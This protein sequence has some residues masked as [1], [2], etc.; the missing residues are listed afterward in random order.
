MKRTVLLVSMFLLS[1]AVR[2]QEN[3]D[4]CS[5]EISLLTC[6]PGADLYSLFGHTAIRVV[7][8]KRG[9]DVVYNYGTFDDSDPAFYL[10]FMRG[11][12]RYSLSAETTENFMQEYEYG[13]RGVTAQVLNLGCDEKNKLFQALRKNTLEEN[14]YYDYFF[15]NDNCTTRAGVMIESQAGDSLHFKNILPDNLHSK[16]TYRDLIHEYL[17]REAATWSEFG[18]DLFLGTNLDKKVSNMD[19]IHFLPDYLFKGLDSAVLRNKPLVSSKKTL[20]DFPDIEKKAGPFRPLSVFEFIFLMTILLFIFNSAPRV[21]KTL[22]FFDIIFFTLLG[23]LGVLMLLMWFGRIDDVCRNNLNICWALPTHLVAVF[24]IRKK[25]SWVKYYFLVTAII[26]A[27]LVA[28]FPWW[29][30]RLNPAVLPLLGIIL[31]RGYWQFQ[32]RNHEKKS[33]VRRKK[34]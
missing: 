4:S 26:A 21:A 15:Q 1:L 12:M 3:S 17:R 19:A 30:Q 33:L 23:L 2:S 7:D 25:T 31:F 16:L 32:I 5:L 6:K 27:L 18:I 9:I 28:G 13:H 34:A 29:P 24:F 8:T 22:L 11:I 20:L 10:K 14:R